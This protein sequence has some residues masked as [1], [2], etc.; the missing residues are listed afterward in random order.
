MKTLRWVLGVLN[1]LFGGFLVF[2]WMVAEG[3][4]ASFG[5]S[6]NSPLEI[7]LPL[8][9]QAVLLAALIA[10]HR[11][12]LL[13]AGAVAALGLAVFCVWAMVAEAA[14]IMGYALVYIAAWL[15]FYWR[16]ATG[17]AGCASRGTAS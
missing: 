15:V 16:A 10:P 7:L 1:A 13:H 9:A 5:A 11:R 12:A 14:T 3:F 17:K 6:E 8:A 4:R 2:L